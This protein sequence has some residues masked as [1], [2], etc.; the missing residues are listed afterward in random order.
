MIFRPANSSDS[1][2]HNFSADSILGKLAHRTLYP[3]HQARRRS[4]NYK[5][6]SAPLDT[7]CL[8]LTRRMSFLVP[9][10]FASSTSQHE[11]SKDASSI[12]ANFGSF[13]T[14]SRPEALSIHDHQPLSRGGRIRQRP[15]PDTRILLHCIHL[16]HPIGSLTPGIRHTINHLI[17]R[18]RC[19]LFTYLS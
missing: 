7:I 3:L 11:V 4:H 17:V 16:D 5:D 19:S 14:T 2:P 6:H 15:R 9:H 8:L 1:Y 18:G 10:Y 12:C 13:H